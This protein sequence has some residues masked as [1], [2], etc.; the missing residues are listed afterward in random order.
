M[1]CIEKG[2]VVGV[3]LPSASFLYRSHF[4]PVLPSR[5]GVKSI[6]KSFLLQNSFYSRKIFLHLLMIPVWMFFL[7]L[8]YS[9]AFPNNIL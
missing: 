6:K 8:L 5:D 9:F 4:L 1:G 2:Q 7:Y 3:I